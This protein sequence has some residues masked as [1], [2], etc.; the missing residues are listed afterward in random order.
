[1][2]TTEPEPELW[3]QATDYTRWEDLG[4]ADDVP[5][6]A[7]TF[8]LQEED[9]ADCSRGNWW[10][11]G[12][13]PDGRRVIYCGSFGN[14]HSPGASHLTEAVVYDVSTDEGA[15][16]YLTYRDEW[17]L[18]PEYLPGEDEPE[19]KNEMAR[20]Y[21]KGAYPLVV[22]VGRNPDDV[23]ARRVL[24]DWLD[25]H[26]RPETAALHRRAADAVERAAQSAARRRADRLRD[27][28]RFFQPRTGAVG[29]AAVAAWNLAHA[30]L[31]RE[32]NEWNHE[33]DPEPGEDVGAVR[34]RW[35]EDPESYRMRDEFPDEDP[36]TEYYV[37]WVEVWD[38]GR[39]EHRAGVG[40]VGFLPGAFP[41]DPYRRDLE[42]ELCSEVMP[43]EDE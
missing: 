26:G 24:A 22:L 4:L 2:T 10:E 7:A 17:E 15:A 3:V 12:T 36:E 32:D 20:G 14:D 29:R 43:D 18:S 33:S 21:P 31:W 23:L 34:V 11:E 13:L 28:W 37:C 19:F 42:A 8:V 25:E 40:G 30:E 9:G 41:G 1:M 39:W 6:E 35:E 38:G 5:T 27:K 16:A